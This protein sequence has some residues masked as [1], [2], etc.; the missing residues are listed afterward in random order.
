MTAGTR[1]GKPARGAGAPPRAPAARGASPAGGARARGTAPP[2]AGRT[3]PPPLAA[4]RPDAAA[5]AAAVLGPLALYAA[6]LPRTV[7]LE[8]DGLFLMAGAHLGVAHPPGYPIHTLIVHLFTRLPF[9][10]AAF[11]G[12]LS[13]AVLGALACGAAYCC[14][15]LLRASPVPALAAAWLFGVSEQ[16]WS[17]AIIAEVYTLNALLFFAVYALVLLGARDPRRGWPLSCAAAAWG[18]G[19]ANHWPLMVLATPGLALALAPVW[20][21]V[22]PRLPRLLGMALA[23][24]AL[25]YAWMVW[26][27]HQ[28]PAISF[29]GPIDTWGDLWFYVSR[30]GYSGVDVSP[31]AGWG[32]RAAYLGWFA[33]DLVRQTTLPGAVLALL[34]LGALARGRLAGTVASGPGPRRTPRPRRV[35]RPRAPT[36]GRPRRARAPTQGRPRRARAPTQGRPRRARA[37]AQGRPRRARPRVGRAGPGAAPTD[38]LAGAAAAG[39]GLLALLGNSVVL[40]GLLGFDFDEFRLAVFRPYPLICYGVAALW[41]AAGLQWAMDRLPGR[42]AARWPAAAGGLRRLGDRLPGRSASPPAAGAAGVREA[43]ADARGASGA[44]VREAPADARGASGAGVREAPGGAGVREA[45]GG[46]GVREA[47]GGAG[48]REAPG[49]ARGA[50]VLAALAGA[51][52]VAWSASG[53]WA[54]NDRSGSDFAERHA[55]VVFDLLPPDAALFV[56]GDALGPV[57]YYR[58]V[59][60]RRPDVALYSLQGLVFGNRLF[61]PLASTEEKQRAL[62][63]FVATADN[64]VF[65]LPDFDVSPAD[66]G[67]GHHGFVL[68][69]LGAGTAGTVDLTRDE[70]GERYFLELLD[71]RPADRWERSR[72]SG[73]LSRYGNYLGL[74][75]LSGSPLLLEPMAGLLERA[76]DCYPC[77]LGMA[78]ALLD[79]DAAGHADRIAAWLE[80]AEALHDQALSKQESARVYFEQGRLAE[81]TG[82]ADTAAARYRLAWAVYPHPDVDAGPALS[83]LGLAP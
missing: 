73:L 65:L 80:R 25:P 19:L 44:G 26:L 8:D 48:V 66:R 51:A 47:P 69:V 22:L 81:L 54:A 41:A 77:L 74:V 50:A 24:A 32:D 82:D 23:S 9:G 61:D 28:G 16:F 30:Q 13:S 79:N 42:A 21:D 75:V 43:P 7:V 78:A 67:F 49:A 72:R 27:S 52:M 5:L 40:I 12:H 70:R 63:R 55:E 56:Y 46:A 36:Q 18:A 29:Y 39:S 35:G 20:R 37:P 45:P 58:Y 4:G 14:A 64:P 15:R 17:Q 83:R 38:A 11:L 6:T 1:R 71:R 62:D 53:G 68:E 34:G 60:E 31:A 2:S 3:G 76:G 57:G 10:D 59:D 33:A